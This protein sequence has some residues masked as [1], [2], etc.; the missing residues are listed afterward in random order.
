MSVID[1]PPQK[2]T[3]NNTR[4]KTDGL[5][6]L[7]DL[8]LF[9]VGTYLIGTDAG[10]EFTKHPCIKIL[11]D[12]LVKIG[13]V[14]VTIAFVDCFYN[15][16]EQI[17]S[18]VVRDPLASNGVAS[19]AADSRKNMQAI[20]ALVMVGLEATTDFVADLDKKSLVSTEPFAGFDSI[21]EMP[22]LEGRDLRSVRAIV[23]Q[24]NR[25]LVAD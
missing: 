8:I 23:Q 4:K 15:E 17:W 21:W 9:W 25:L 24:I 13:P 1:Q 5:V 3:P 18:S 20:W 11:L 2:T 16:P 7:G 10:R 14:R 19:R 12:E 22:E 6:Y